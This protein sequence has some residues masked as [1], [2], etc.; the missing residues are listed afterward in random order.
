MTKPRHARPWNAAILHELRRLAAERKMRQE[1]IAE[2]AGISQ[3]T[4]SRLLTGRQDLC[5]DDLA[6]LAEAM[7]AQPMSVIERARRRADIGE[8]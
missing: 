8:R 3:S 6:R 7:R 2:A 1:D 4:V 5:L